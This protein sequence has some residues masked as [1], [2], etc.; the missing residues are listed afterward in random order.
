MT[1]PS[2]NAIIVEDEPQIRRF[3]RLAL[4]AL[5]QSAAIRGVMADL[6]AG[7]QPYRRLE[8]RLLGTLEL[9]L[10]WRLFSDRWRDSRR[11]R[12]LAHQ[13]D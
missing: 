7:R 6:I 4:D 10:A 8:R 12:A 2:L 13:A 9:G 3:V 1:E 11:G 5:A